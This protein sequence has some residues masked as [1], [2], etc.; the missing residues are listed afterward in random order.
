MMRGQGIM[1]LPTVTN[2]TTPPVAE[3]ES[4]RTA[5]V[6]NA[7]VRIR[8]LL[9]AV[10]VVVVALAYE[11]STRLSF[12]RSVE[13]MFAPDDPLLVPYQKLKRTFGG[14]EI[15]LAAYVEGDLMSEK[16]IGRVGE[17]TG[18]LREVDGVSDVLSLSTTPLGEAIIDTEQPLSG[19]FIELFEG[20]TIGRDRK[21]AAVVCMLEP[22]KRDS[23]AR[24]ETVAK[25]TEI[26]Q[27]HDSSG[28]LTGEPVMVVEGFR[29]IEDDGRRLGLLATGLLMLTIVILFRSLRWVIIPVAVVW[30]TL[31]VTRAV[32]VVGDFRLS[33][34]SSM[35]WAIVTVTGI[36]MVIHIIVRFREARGEGL[37][38]RDAL[39]ICGAALAVPVAWTCCT[40]A[41]GFGALTA[42]RVGPMQDFGVMMSMA[43]L[44]ALVSV[45][46]VLP[47]LALLGRFDSDPHRAWGERRLDTAL[48]RVVRSVERWPKLLGLGTLVLVT[49]SAVGFIWLEVET[50]FT[51]NFRSSSQIVKSYEFVE[52]NLGGG[53]VWDILLPVPEE[54]DWDYLGRVRGLEE[55]LRNE[56]RVENEKGEVVAGLTKVLS[57][58]DVL[59]AFDAEQLAENEAFNLA[60]M[61]DV[62]RFQ[63]PGAAAALLGEDP[64]SPGEK[65][66]RIMLRARERQPSSQKSSLIAQVEQISHEEFS[67]AEV[68]GFFVLL[69]NLIDSVIRDQYVTFS[70]AL[71]AIGLMMLLAFRSLPLAAAALVPNI[72]PILIVTGLMGWLGVRINMGAAMIAAVSMGLAIDSS[73]HY[74]T[75]YR[76]LRREGKPHSESIDAAHQ[77][78]GRAM[79]FSSLALIV[80][81]SAL[82]LSE[83][84][85]VIYFGVLVGLSML[86]GLLG[87]LVV[88]PLLL[89]AIDRR[90]THA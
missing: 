63:M 21:T 82:C 54:L 32:L 30:A 26:V 40:D 85:P 79:F 44:V 55:R 47:G 70:I 83:F 86:G 58:V 28:V 36:A 39:L 75:A 22:S 53:G 56:V 80:G 8:F 11:P 3:V 87:N 66:L 64:D 18:K 41:A 33:M 10:A 37:T 34:V 31:V 15:A 71:L 46:V 25:L 76:N 19:R 73:I 38:P 12:D 16:G 74:I 23:L 35:M 9:L 67:R 29:L 7:L 81:F 68:T 42:A 50:D 13:N 65:Y 14:N 24:D 60:A 20:Y 52:E 72:L 45:A 78:V 57:V 27:A 62:F 88:L 59:D 48:R 2:K 5:R 90:G 84:V 6:V 43:S 17:L 77:S 4:S 61:V 1:A 49:F 89:R 69:T 51:K